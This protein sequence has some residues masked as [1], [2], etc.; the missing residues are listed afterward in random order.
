MIGVE[1]FDKI[2]ER[3]TAMWNREIFDRCCISVNYTKPEIHAELARPEGMDPQYYMTDAD[4]MLKRNLKVFENTYY[5]GDAFPVIDLNMG[6]AGHAG[7]IQGVDVDYTENTFWFGPIMEDELNAEKIIFDETSYLYRQVNYAAKYLCE[8]ANSR[9]LVSMSDATGNLDVLAFLR[10]STELLQ[11]MITDE[12]EVIKCLQRIQAIWKKTTREVYDIV[13]DYSFGGSCIG[14]LNTWAPGLHAQIQSDVSVMISNDHFEKFVRSELEEQSALMDHALYHLDG[15]E[16]LRHLDTLLSVKDIKM[17]Q[18]QPVVG[19]PPTTAF[20]PVLR[21]IQEAGKC[22]HLFL[23]P[24]EIE[25]IMTNLSSRGLFIVTNASSKE[26]A[27]A[28]VKMAGKL[29]HE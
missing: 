26:D 19:Q 8:E 17:I 13:K 7:F 9:Y 25:P 28:I 5:A 10:T 22:L 20:I 16:Q 3:F 18:W 4:M 27:D 21:K 11:D 29:T 12:E 2:K 23:A 14:W 6:A 1:N 24:H 15:Q